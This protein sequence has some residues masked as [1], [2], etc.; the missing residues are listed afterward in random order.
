M[1]GTT[2]IAET[3]ANTLRNEGLGVEVRA[4][5]AVKDVT[6]YDAVVVGGALYASRW[7]KDARRLVKRNASILKGKPVWLFS[8]G[9][10]DDS[11]AVGDL[12]PVEMVRRLMT[13]I[14]ARGHH[15][16]GGRLPHDVE[17]FPATAMAKEHSGDWRDM[18]QVTYWATQIASEL[19]WKVETV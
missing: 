1:G 16:F 6:P 4:A 12:A 9:P 17:W 11:A 14:E 3:V 7:H 10:L 18:A 13:L 19:S 5:G 2:G 15:T 8:S